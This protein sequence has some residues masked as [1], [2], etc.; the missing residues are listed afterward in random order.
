MQLAH[1]TA[2]LTE[3]W[4]MS[5]HNPSQSFYLQR[6]CACV[7]VV[8]V[9]LW[10]SF[11]FRK[12]IPICQGICW[13]ELHV[14]SP[15]QTPWKP[16]QKKDKS[17]SLIVSFVG[18]SS[19]TTLGC[20]KFVKCLTPTL[21]AYGQLAVPPILAAHS[22]KTWLLDLSRW[23]IAQSWDSGFQGNSVVSKAGM[24]LKCDSAK[25]IIMFDC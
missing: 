2:H 12:Y 14:I 8:R 20:W 4:S 24:I 3:T 22:R 5:R 19:S 21:W 10:S 11:S 18:S 7:C 23:I 13:S 17:R 1:A 25:N 9:F 16:C 15:G 6:V